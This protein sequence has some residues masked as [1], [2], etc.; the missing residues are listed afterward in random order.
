MSVRGDWGITRRF[1]S[2]SLKRDDAGLWSV[3]IGPSLPIVV[4]YDLEGVGRAGPAQRVSVYGKMFADRDDAASAWDIACELYEATDRCAPSVPRPV[5]FSEQMHLVLTESAGL[6]GR[7]GTDV[8]RPIGPTSTA[9]LVATGSLLAWLHSTDAKA[10]APA[11][12]VRA[13]IEPTRRRAALLAAE[14][15]ALNGDLIRVGDVVATA[16]DVCHRPAHEVLTHGAFKPSQLVFVS[17]RPVVT[18]LDGAAI[19]DPAYDVGYLRAYLR[20][21]GCWGRRT[22]ARAWFASAREIVT[23]TYVDA[24]YG[25]VTRQAAR[26]LRRRAGIVEAAILFKIGARRVNRLQA[27]RPNEVRA[28]LTD[29]ER[30]L[31]QAGA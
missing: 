4:R 31:A 9:D 30:C 21:A 20:P 16:L 24:V 22:V 8:L 26:D 7:S 12:S 5:A 25:S 1:E 29:V 23:D 13:L 15:G 2:A 27:P 18:D 6:A 3:T 10:G 17:G 19:G 28:M 14:H 11:R